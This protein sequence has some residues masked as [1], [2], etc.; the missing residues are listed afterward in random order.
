MVTAPNFRGRGWSYTKR[1]KLGDPKRSG[2]WSASTIHH[3]YMQ[4][5]DYR[6]WV[7]KYESGI[8][9]LMVGDHTP[10]SR[11][12][13][14]QVASL[15]M[16]DP[17]FRSYYREGVKTVGNKQYE[18]NMCLSKGKGSPIWLSLHWGTY[19]EEIY[20]NGDFEYIFPEY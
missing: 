5:K 16:K 11:L 15:A 14:E 13:G 7:Q 18:A 3:Q 8:E 17:Y 9:V 20:P 6:V 12:M 4:H 19:R 2:N 1:T 10:L